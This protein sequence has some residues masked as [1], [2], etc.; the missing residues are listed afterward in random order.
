MEPFLITHPLSFNHRLGEETV[1][2]NQLM[3]E[4]NIVAP[5]TFG[6]HQI[7]HA[8]RTTNELDKIII[9][10]GEFG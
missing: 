1:I 4:R 2:V 6:I 7:E 10:L 3:A 8:L 5:D 9:S